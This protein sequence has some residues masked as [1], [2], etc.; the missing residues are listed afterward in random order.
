M[1]KNKRLDLL[2]WALMI[3]A[4]GTA[5]FAGKRLISPSAPVPRAPAIAILDP[6]LRAI[7]REAAGATSKR[8]GTD[9]TR[10][11]VVF[12]DFRCPASTALGRELLALRDDTLIADMVYLH[13]PTLTSS[14][15]DARLLASECAALQGVFE[16]YYRF[17]ASRDGF[18]G[19]SRSD[20]ISYIASVLHSD[21]IQQS[22][23]VSCV[24]TDGAN[25]AIESDISF[26]ARL[27]L[28]A[29][30]TIVFDDSLLVEGV[31]QLPR[32]R[33]LLLPTGEGSVE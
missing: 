4:L 20:T 33:Q 23:F 5:S 30:P 21:P 27:S 25:S 9:G 24:M 29:T 3:V 31:V 10:R 2:T 17:E 16:D 22:M 13:Y 18:S 26:A 6:D 8:I 15:R 28:R 11:I 32:L 19:G 12:G 7:V 14:T 1:A